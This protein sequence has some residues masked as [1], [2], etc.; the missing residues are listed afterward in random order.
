MRHPLPYHQHRGGGLLE[1]HH[2]QDEAE[3]GG[4]GQD[5]WHWLLHNLQ[6][7]RLLGA[8][9]D[10]GW[11]KEHVASGRRGSLLDNCQVGQ[12]FS[13]MQSSDCRSSSRRDLGRWRCPRSCRAC[14]SCVETIPE[15]EAA[16]SRFTK[17]GRDEEPQNTGWQGCKTRTATVC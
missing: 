7:E 6:G 2:H 12:V 15:G 17:N 9:P 14:W 13:K 1:G 11:V 4:R 10:G 3:R 5:R 16:R 8:Q